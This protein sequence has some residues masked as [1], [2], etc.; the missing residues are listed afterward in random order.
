M[1]WQEKYD[2]VDSK[3]KD[4]MVSNAQLYNEKNAL[5]Y[6]VDNLKDRCVCVC[7]C[8][9]VCLCVSVCV[10]VCIRTYYVCIKVCM[11]VCVC[12]CV[13]VFP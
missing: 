1:L 11:Y 9:C 13:A 4:A 10:C 6:T 5:Y 3:Y 12:G 8:V 7:V 2:E